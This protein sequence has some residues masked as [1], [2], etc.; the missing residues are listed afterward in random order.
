MIQ[1]YMVDGHPKIM[2]GI[3]YGKWIDDF[4]PNLCKTNHTW[5]TNEDASTPWIQAAGRLDPG[6]FSHWM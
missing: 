1:K 6:G 2:N 4:S 3:P 5:R